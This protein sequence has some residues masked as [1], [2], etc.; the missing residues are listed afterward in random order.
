LICASH[1][2]TIRGQS[3]RKGR[4]AR[5]ENLHL[6]RALF[7]SSERDRWMESTAFPN[8]T[9][10]KDRGRVEKIVRKRSLS[11]TTNKPKIFLSSAFPLTN[12]PKTRALGATFSGMRHR[13]RLRSETRW[14]E[15]PEFGYFKMVAPRALVFRPLVKE[16]EDSGNEIV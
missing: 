11:V 12:G 10:L 15:S 5:P 9:P 8:K 3:F 13:C 1:P 14:T 2:N 7:S 4:N 6:R 16:N